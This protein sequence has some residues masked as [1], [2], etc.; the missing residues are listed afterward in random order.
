MQQEKIA[1]GKRLVTV[2]QLGFS[3]SDSSVLICHK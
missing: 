3:E 1:G 2:S